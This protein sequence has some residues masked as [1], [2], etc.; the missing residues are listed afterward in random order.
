VNWINTRTD[1]YQVVAHAQP[2][3]FTFFTGRPA[4]LLPVNLTPERLRELLVSYEIDYVLLDTRDRARRDYSD[5]LRDLEDAGVT[6]TTLGAY[7]IFDVRALRDP[8]E[9]PRQ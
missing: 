6:R 4:A 8:V 2:W 5:D 1:R 9:E 7:E 3:P